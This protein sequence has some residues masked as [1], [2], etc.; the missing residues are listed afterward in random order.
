MSK[1]PEVGQLNVVG[2][3]EVVVGRG[4]GGRGRA[5]GLGDSWEIGRESGQRATEAQV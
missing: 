4:R 5:C 1:G 2:G 3:E